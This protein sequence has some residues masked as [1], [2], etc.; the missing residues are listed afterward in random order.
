M[1]APQ[2]TLRRLTADGLLLQLRL[3]D[4]CCALARQLIIEGLDPNTRL[5]FMRGDVVCLARDGEGVRKPAI[6]G[7]K[8]RLTIMQVRD[9][10]PRAFNERAE[11]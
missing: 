5:E 11:K 6:A 1:N 2:N 3:P 7:V 4:D 10:L 9:P 8:Q